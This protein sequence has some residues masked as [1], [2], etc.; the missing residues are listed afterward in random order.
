[1]AQISVPPPEN[2]IIGQQ[3]LED[4]LHDADPTLDERPEVW[5]RAVAALVQPGLELLVAGL[6]DAWHR[7][8]TRRRALQILASLTDHEP[9]PRLRSPQLRAI[10]DGYR[11]ATRSNVGA[12]AAPLFVS[13]MLEGMQ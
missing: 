4:L 5:T 3:V 6:R 13:R 11:L 2:Y 10:V 8:H 7:H 1:M 12:I 9:P